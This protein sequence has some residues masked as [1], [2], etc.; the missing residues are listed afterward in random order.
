[1]GKYGRGLEDV[2]LILG[3]T[4]IIRFDYRIIAP[5][6]QTGVF[7]SLENISLPFR[8][9]PKQSDRSFSSQALL[10]G[11]SFTS[12]YLAVFF[13][14]P[15]RVADKSLARPGRKQ[16]ALVKSVMGRGMD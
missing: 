10:P 4:F 16:A 6:N 1:M 15:Y 9:A 12:I 5:C 7:V 2:L 3:R 14:Q 8:L 11:S 13:I